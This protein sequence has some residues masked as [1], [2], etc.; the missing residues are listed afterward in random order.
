MPCAGEAAQAVATCGRVKKRQGSRKAKRQ[1]GGDQARLARVEQHKRKRPAVALKKRPASRT[2]KEAGDTRL[3]R[4]KRR[5]RE[6]PAV[7]LRRGK[8][9]GSKGAGRRGS[10]ATCAGEA[11][12]KV[13]DCVPNRFLWKARACAGKAAQAGAT[14]GRVESG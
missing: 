12:Q 14:C 9:A 2:G 8:E 6:G 3:A 13:R 7:A 10:S 5:K 1:G 4:V 11:A